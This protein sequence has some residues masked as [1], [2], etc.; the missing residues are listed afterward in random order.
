MADF[1]LTG[2]HTSS[3]LCVNTQKQSG[4]IVS[5]G[6]DGKLCVWT[7]EGKLATSVERPDSCCT[8]AIFSSD[9]PNIVY[10]AFGEEILVLDITRSPH[11]IHTFESNTDEINQL[12]YDFKER[13][14]GACDDSGEVKIYSIQDKKV[15][16]TL[17]HK[18]TNICS[19][20]AFRPG[21]PWEIISGGLDCQ[22]V[23]WDFSKAK[24]LNQFNTQKLFPTPGESPHMINP[25]FVHHIASSPIGTQIACALENGQIPILDCSKKHLKPVYTLL[26]HT[27]GVSQVHF[28][29]ENTLISSGN[30]S[31]IHE[32]DL[33]KSNLYDQNVDSSSG[34]EESSSSGNEASSSSGNEERASE[35]S[36]LCRKRT[37]Q[38]N[39]KINWLSIDSKDAHQR[40]LVADDTSEID[41]INL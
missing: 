21:R 40:L 2:G 29:N 1:K 23:H 3:V 12:D 34:N 26:A 38:R 18:H 37:I 15:F 22:F 19:T 36:S 5:G 24:C 35:I 17:R 20:I 13:Y 8:S 16:K 11:P 39:G 28:L 31:C 7:P 32:W 41:V 25:P 10:A 27:Q 14:L 6:E 30:D 33:T 4:Q 9:N